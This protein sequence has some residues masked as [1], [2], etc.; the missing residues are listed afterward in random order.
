MGAISL[1]ELQLMT[2]TF[3]DQTKHSQY[4]HAGDLC[5]AHNAEAYLAHVQRV[6]VAG[7]TG[8]GV[9]LVRICLF[10]RISVQFMQS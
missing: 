6:V 4:F 5:D 8:S 7:A 1:E 9:D 3:V 2:R 10:I